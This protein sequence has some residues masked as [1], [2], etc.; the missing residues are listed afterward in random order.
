MTLDEGTKWTTDDGL[1]TDSISVHG[2][3][4]VYTVPN[5][6]F[7]YVLGAMEAQIWENLLQEIVKYEVIFQER[8]IFKYM[9]IELPQWEI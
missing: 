3:R 1:R 4:L 8:V 6:Q 5:L 7:I 9:E 2:D